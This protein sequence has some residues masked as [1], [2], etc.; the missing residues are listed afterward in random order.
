DQVI[1]KQAGELKIVNAG[2]VSIKNAMRLEWTNFEEIIPTISTKLKESTICY[3]TA[4]PN[5]IFERI[6]QYHSMNG[7]KINKLLLVNKQWYYNASRLIWHKITLTDISRVK[8]TNALS[9]NTKPKSCEQ[10]LSLKFIGTINIGPDVYIS[11]VCK[12]CANLQQLSFENCKLRIIN[13]KNLE[14]LL[15]ECPN[16]K[17]LAIRGSRRLSPKTITK[18]PKLA[19]NLKTIEISN[20]LQIKKDIIADFQNLYPTIRLIFVDQLKQ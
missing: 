10:V 20:C 17:L 14:A 16:L 19:P 1:G 11:E 5:E 2:N 12:A 15:V 13:N 4:M 9:K 7:K 6:F 3:V 18:I 8:F